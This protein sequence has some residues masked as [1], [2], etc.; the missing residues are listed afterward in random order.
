[1]YLEPDTELVIET[2]Q[3]V[4]LHV[5]YGLLY[6]VPEHLPLI[7][8]VLLVLLHTALLVLKRLLPHLANKFK[9]PVI[10]PGIP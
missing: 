5:M 8:A 1:M 4:L 9:K 10:S 3:V 6:T 2:G 7:L